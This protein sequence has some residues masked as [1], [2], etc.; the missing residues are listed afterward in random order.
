[1]SVFGNYMKVEVEPITKMPVI[2]VDLGDD[3]VEYRL[4]ARW[5]I[6][7][8]CE[9]SQSHDHPA[10]ANG[11]TA[12]EMYELGDDFRDEYISGLYSVRCE[13]CKGSGRDAQLDRDLCEKKFPGV[14]ALYDAF[15]EDCVAFEMEMEA[16]RRA[17]C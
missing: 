8:R 5:V 10:F 12:E 11:I 14:A 2:V 15:L 4:P 16:E 1:M 9:G 7:W 17:G 6:C 3:E 13:N